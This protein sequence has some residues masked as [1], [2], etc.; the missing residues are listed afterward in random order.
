MNQSA[1]PL[2]DRSGWGDAA[3]GGRTIGI[4]D[5]GRSGA[6]I[7]CPEAMRNILDLAAR[8][9]IPSA[10]LSGVLVANGLPGMRGTFIF[11]T[12]FC[13]MLNCFWPSKSPSVLPG[14]PVL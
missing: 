9:L 12:V 7:G 1:V 13:S 6:R 10:M 8:L 5:G 14:G 4:E 11:R 2:S 3:L